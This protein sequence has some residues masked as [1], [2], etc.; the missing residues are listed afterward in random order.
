MP[1]DNTNSLLIVGTGAMA[2]LFAAR[3]SAARVRVI[4]LG[5]WAE[6]LQTL[7][8]HGVRLVEADGQERVYAVQATH[9]PKACRGVRHALVLVKSWQT[10]RAAAQLAECLAADGLALS[11]QNGIGNTEQLARALGAKRVALGVTTLGA[12]LLGPGRVRPAGEGIIS[13]SAHP[14]LAALSNVFR[15]AGFVIENAPDASALLWGKLVINAAINPLTALL[16]V[17]NGELLNR[18]PARALLQ[19]TAREA[20]AVAVAQGIRLPYPDPVVAAENIARRTA[21]NHSSMLQDVQRGAPTEIDAICGAI[22]RA[23]EQTGVP[24][25]INRT[26]LLLVGALTPENQDSR[27]H[28]TR[29]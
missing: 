26:L 12:T 27:P 13:L 7:R 22:V 9:D 8:Q 21:D 18:S 16:G 25:P 1:I 17:P 23:G 14:R 19:A 6:G 5:A 3:L 2:C 28:S 20:A 29:L 24:T 11:L 4:M 15:S 10:P